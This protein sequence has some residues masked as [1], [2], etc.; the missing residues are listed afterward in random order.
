MNRTTPILPQ[1]VA[2]NSARVREAIHDQTGRAESGEP[3]APVPPAA[4]GV[5]VPAHDEG[6]RQYG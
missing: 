5:A 3:A 4:T 1:H 2:K 6:T